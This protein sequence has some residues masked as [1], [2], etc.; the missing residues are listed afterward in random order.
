MRQKVHKNP[1]ELLLTWL[2]NTPF[3]DSPKMW[4]IYQV[5]NNWRKLIFS[6]VSS[7][8]L[9]IA[10]R[11]GMKIRSTSSSQCWNLT[12]LELIQALCILPQS[13]WVHM[14]ISPDVSGRHYFLD[15]LHHPELLH[16]SWCPI[17]PRAINTLSDSSFSY[18]NAFCGERF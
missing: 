13:L 11:S 4:L 7:C 17:S 16:S 10:S 8:Q 18:L 3:V 9:E 12:W 15:A 14:S 5:R 1:T 6:F 2:C